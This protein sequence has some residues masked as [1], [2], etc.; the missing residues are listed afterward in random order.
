[1]LILGQPITE[2]PGIMALIISILLTLFFN[3]PLI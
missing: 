2:P 3:T 1:V